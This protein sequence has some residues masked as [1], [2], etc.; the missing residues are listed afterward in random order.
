MKPELVELLQSL[1]EI[2]K[3]IHLRSYHTLNDMQIYPGQPKLIMLIKE[4]EGITQRELAEKNFVTPSTITGMLSKLEVKNYIYRV[5]DTIDKRIMRV[6]LT[7][8][9]QTFAI[10]ANEFINSMIEQIFD[11]IDDE[12]LETLQRLSQKLKNNIHNN[13][14]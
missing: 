7:P 2:I 3:F 14:S 1:A 6:Y 13:E 9:G 4:N 12:E 5:P 8:E 10:H 11:G